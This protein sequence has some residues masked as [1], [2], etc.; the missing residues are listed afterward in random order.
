MRLAHPRAWA[1]IALLVAA[2]PAFALSPVPVTIGPSRDGTLHD[3]QKVVDRTL[4][5]GRIDVHT[6][7]LGADAGDPDPWTWTSVA[8][9]AVVLTLVDKKLSSGTLGWYREG[10]GA[11]RLDGADSGVL[12]ERGR[13]RG[14]SEWLR[15]PRTV[16]RFGFYIVREP[17]DRFIDGD[18]GGATYYSNRMLNDVGPHGARA[19]HAPWDGDVQMLVY[20]I[21]RWTHSDT[22]LVACEYSDSGDPLGMG[23][24]ESDNDYTDIVFTVSGVGVTPT[25]SSTFGNLKALF[26]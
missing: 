13:L 14:T 2:L 22:W 10:A 5:P 7:Y 15:L 17:G 12:F 4:G 26:R 19:T 1:A 6:D 9:R 11:P 8:G 20:D 16:T 25:R 21:S 24:G 23:E 18:D 3:L